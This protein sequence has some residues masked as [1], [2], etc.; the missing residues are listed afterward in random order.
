MFV[1]P[2]HSIQYLLWGDPLHCEPPEDV[3]APKGTQPCGPWQAICPY[4]APCP[5]VR[6]VPGYPLGLRMCWLWGRP[7]ISLTEV[8]Q[9]GNER[10]EKGIVA[11]HVSR[12][13]EW[14][15]KAMPWNYPAYGLMQCP[16]AYI[17]G[18]TKDD[19]ILSY[20]RAD[21]PI[22]EGGQRTIRELVDH[23]WSLSW[24]LP[25]AP[26]LPG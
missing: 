14:T 1:A 20:Q 5:E 13:V 6:I 21:Q 4:M 8:Q 12:M 11:L 18:F 26:T 19:V 9:E 3:E 17:G 22:P 10:T 25:D 24:T 2:A 23:L 16:L 15:G 7:M